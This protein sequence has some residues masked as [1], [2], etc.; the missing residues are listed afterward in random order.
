MLAVDDVDPLARQLAHFCAVIRGEAAPLV[1]VR[2]G[3]QNLRITEA[4]GEA[5]ATG[6][7]IATA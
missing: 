5:A 6:R 3:L 4:I 2:D 1:G 7:L